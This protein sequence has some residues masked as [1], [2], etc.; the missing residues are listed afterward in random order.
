MSRWPLITDFSRMLQNPKVAFRDAELKTSAVEKNNLGQPKPRSGNFATVY[1]GFRGVGQEF[2]IRVYNRAAAERRERYA[3]VH[4]YLHDK[5]VSCLV[6]F[7]YDEKGIR[8]TDGKMY[9]LI[10]MDWVPGVTLFEWARQRSRE[11]YQQAF[12]IAADVWLQLIRDL[13][14]ARLVHGDLQ[15]GNILISQEGQFKLVDYDCMA[16][17]ALMGRR[18]LEMGMVPYQHPARN[19]ETILFD[20][21]DHFSALVIYVALRALAAETTLWHKYVDEPEYDKMLFRSQD[22]D[23]PQQS[24]LYHDLMKSPDRQVRDLSHYLFELARYPIDQVPPLDEVLLWCH[25]IE[26]LLK[27]REWDKAVQLHKR[28]GPNEQVPQ[29]LMAK[30]QQAY[31]RVACRDALEKALEAGNDAEIQ[32]CYNPALLDDYP[33]AAPLVERARMAGQVR[34]ILSTLDSTKQAG[35]WPAFIQT[36]RKHQQQINDLPTGQPYKQEMLRLI[37]ATNVK[38]LLTSTDSDDRAVLEEWKLLE[39][40][41]GHPVAEALRP[42]VAKCAAREKVRGLVQQAPATPN[43]TYD[44]ELAAGIRAGVLT[45][46]AGDNQLRTYCEAARQRLKMLETFQKLNKLNTLD[47]EN[48]IISLAKQLPEG[49]HAGM[50]RRLKQAKERLKAFNELTDTLN[51]PVSDMAV[52]AAHRALEHAGGGKLVGETQQQRLELA[53]QRAPV[54]RAIRQIN[55]SLPLDDYDK[56]LLTIWKEELLAGCLDAEEYRPRYEQAVERKQL[57]P[58]LNAA[59]EAEDTTAVAQL[60]ASPALRGYPME[61]ELAEKIDELQNRAVLAKQQQRH[62]LMQS[63]INNERAAFVR[64]FDI[65]MVRE[66]GQ[67]HTHHQA[68]MIRWIEEEI[69]PPGNCGLAP[70]PSGAVTIVDDN[71]CQLRWNWPAASVTDT[72]HLVV[73][74]SADVGVHAIPSDLDAIHLAEVSRSAYNA[75]GC[76]EIEVDIAWHNSTVVVWA[77]VDAGFQDFFTPPVKLGAIDAAPKKSKRWGIF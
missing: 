27:A 75:A 14:S 68:T 55:R 5:E 10:T 62:G 20:G 52:V 58:Q 11:G 3:A 2:A 17:P 67:S 48:Q 12:S 34:Q 35:N 42:H 61:L 28:M 54:I 53:H 13:K 38:R 26:D 51:D 9:P 6:D 59:V 21:L 8:S 32:R 70:V 19:A 63:L 65:S 43:V 46:S 4:D 74:Q 36:Y 15:H 64:Q 60:M 56:R 30:L 45:A 41:G 22:F 33:A 1:K 69:L 23:D 16:V 37:R 39:E 73:T 77:H 18:N 57:L 44:R 7:T 31:Q 66:I 25:S 72:C 50:P 47:G 76:Y 24:A 71:R 40:I 29:H 49:Y